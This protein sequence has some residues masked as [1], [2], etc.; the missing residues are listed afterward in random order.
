[1]N[2]PG[3]LFRDATTAAPFADLDCDR[4]A[5]DD[6]HEA[7]GDI[8]EEAAL[9]HMPAGRQIDG[10]L[11]VCGLQFKIDWRGFAVIEGVRKKMDDSGKRCVQILVRSGKAGIGLAERTRRQRMCSQHKIRVT[12]KP[13]IDADDALI[14]RAGLNLLGVEPGLVAF[15]FSD[16]ALAEEQNI[17]HHIRAG[18]GAETALGQADCGDQVG[19][20]GDVLTGG[21]IRLVHGA[22][23]G[24]EGGERSRFQEIDRARDE[25]VVQPQA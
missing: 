19:R 24:D 20:F 3:V 6:L 2:D 11:I 5:V 25:I 10:G 9:T 13:S 7:F 18:I 8:D 1:M 23:A 14:L 4:L 16:L 12:D 22:G 15:G 17:D 21:T